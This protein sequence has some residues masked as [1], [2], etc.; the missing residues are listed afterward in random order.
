M[1]REGGNACLLEGLLY[2]EIIELLFHLA[3]EQGQ[4]AVHGEEIQAGGEERPDQAFLGKPLGAHD[5]FGDADDAGE[6]GILCQGNQLIAHSGGDALYNLHQDDAEKDLGFG[7]AQNLPC[8]ML[9]L[10]N[11]LQ[12]AAVDFGKIGGVIDN[13]GELCGE[14]AVGHGNPE[15]KPGGVQNDKKLEHQ[16]SSPDDPDE[17][18]GDQAERQKFC[19]GAEHDHDA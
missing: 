19:P 8:L 7:H 6:G 2:F 16:G 17:G 14:E 12:A 15:Q 3:K 18:P 5:D 9:S 1:P 11:A 13:E 4:N 10:G